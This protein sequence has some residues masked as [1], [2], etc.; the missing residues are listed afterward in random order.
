M[1]LNLSGRNTIDSDQEGIYLSL[2][3]I[4]FQKLFLN[5]VW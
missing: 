3:D 2:R 1:L 5:K 4:S